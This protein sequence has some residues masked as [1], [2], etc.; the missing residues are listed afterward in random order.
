M[1]IIQIIYRSLNVISVI[2]QPSFRFSEGAEVTL[3]FGRDEP[4]TV[5]AAPTSDKIPQLNIFVKLFLF[6]RLR[7]ND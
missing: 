6:G 5:M 1:T 7:P 3:R 4:P 2:W